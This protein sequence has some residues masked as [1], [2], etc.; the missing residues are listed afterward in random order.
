MNWGAMMANPKS[1]GNSFERE[2][3]TILSKWWTGADDCVF[4]RTSSSG[5]RATQ[6]AKK[7]NKTKNHYGDITTT[8]PIGQP[9]LDIFTLELKRGYSVHTIS[10][11]LDISNREVL[12]QYGQ[13]IDGIAESARHAGSLSWALIVKR[14]RKKTLFF[15]SAQIIQTLEGVAGKRL[16][17]IPYIGIEVKIKGVVHSVIGMTLEGFLEAVKPSLIRLLAG[18]QVKRA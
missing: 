11:L 18:I 5:G 4:W 16:L 17:P 6:R 3:C 14:N 12:P 8:D 13:W 15:T 7:G 9:F 10:D 1:K 2:I